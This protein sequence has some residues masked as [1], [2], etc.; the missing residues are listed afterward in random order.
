VTGKSPLPGSFP[1]EAPRALYGL[2]EDHFWFSHRRTAILEAVG[3]CLPEGQ[4]ARVLEVGCGDG[5]ILAPLSRR[6][7]AVGIDR[8][9]GDLLLARRRGARRLVAGDGGPDMPFGPGFDL[10]GLFDVVEHVEDDAGFLRTAASLAVPGGFVLVTVPADPR[11]WGK[12]DQYA[13]HYRRYTRNAVTGLLQGAGL[14]VLQV[15]P[16]FRALWPLARIGAVLQR[17]TRV[18]DPAREYRVARPWNDLLRRILSVERRLFGT[19]ES[20][21]G[22]S[23][24]AVARVGTDPSS[25]K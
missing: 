12:F 2:K 21:I 25:Q 22:T 13:G 7:R 4:D 6:F 5:E 10:I 15:L 16:L 17:N 1:D 3:A 14:E 8:R 20:G 19:S 18:T 23:W 11:L 24:L 9:V